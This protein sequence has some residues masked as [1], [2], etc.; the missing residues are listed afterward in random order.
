MET[1]RRAL[2]VV[3]LCAILIACGRSAYGQGCGWCAPPETG[4]WAIGT[5]SVSLHVGNWSQT[6]LAI[7]SNAVAT[8]NAAG[9][10]NR[11]EVVNQIGV[12]SDV[13]I[14]ASVDWGASNAH[15]S[16]GRGTIRVHNGWINTSDPNSNA[17]RFL[18]NI[19]LHELGHSLGL[20]DQTW[21]ECGPL[22]TVMW[23]QIAYGVPELYMTGVNYNDGCTLQSHYTP[24]S[25]NPEQECQM[26]NGFW[27]GIRCI[28]YEEW[29]SPLI[30]DLG[31]QGLVLSSVS[32]GVRF[33]LDADGTAEQLSW[34]ARGADDAFLALD[35]NGDG[36]ID[37]GRELFGTYTEQPRSATPNGFAA[38]GVFDENKDGWIDSRDGVFQQL[39]LWRDS[40]H[41]GISQEDELLGLATAGVA[42]VSLDAARST[43]HDRHGNILR[44]RAP[45]VT[46][47]KSDSGRFVYDVFLVVTS[48][49]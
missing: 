22:S 15:G 28:P 29:H 27:D 13:T 9:G 14:N 34:T 49:R 10:A 36:A 8:W 37:S 26:Q 17:G 5:L 46:A 19:L 43:R 7:L 16:D 39:V 2:N 30:V 31:Q 11:F 35:R 3:F 4:T 25:P 24:T 38:L 32:D 42:R 33:D 47:E 44:Y 41:D 12:G 21:S 40:N 23:Y 48:D 18:M 20:A 6:D 1:R 45:I